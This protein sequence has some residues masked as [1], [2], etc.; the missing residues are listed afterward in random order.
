MASTRGVLRG[1][2]DPV[3]A[4]A[5]AGV[6]LVIGAILMILGSIGRAI[7]GRRHYF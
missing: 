1:I 3:V 7:G 5:P 2:I 6:P 4:V